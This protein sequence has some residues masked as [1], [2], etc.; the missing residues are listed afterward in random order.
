MKFPIDYNCHKYFNRR[1]SRAPSNKTLYR[2]DR[3]NSH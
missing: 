2:N 3:L 1:C